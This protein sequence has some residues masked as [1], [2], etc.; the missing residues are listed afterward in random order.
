MTKYYPVMINIENKNCLVIGGG[1]VALR[2]IKSLLDYDVN[3]TVISPELCSELED[4]LSQNRI[5]WLKKNYNT[6]DIKDSNFIFVATNDKSVNKMVYKEAKKKNILVNVVDNSDLCDFIIPSK[7]KRGDLTISISTNGK[8]P[9]LTKKIREELEERFGDS[10][11]TFVNLLGKVRELASERI[12]DIKIRE[13]LYKNLVYSDYIEQLNND[14]KNQV[15]KRMIELL[16]TYKK[17]Y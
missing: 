5:N 2:K 6:I 9:A 12:K 3:I 13:A 14:N 10:Y 4:I 17:D 8:S 16:E 11:E 7:V 1:K 15:K